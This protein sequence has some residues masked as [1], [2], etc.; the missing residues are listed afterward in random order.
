MGKVLVLSL[1]IILSSS[2][3]AKAQNNEFPYELKKLDYALVGFSAFSKYYAYY[4]EENQVRMTVEELL[5]L[6]RS[7][8]NA[9]DR[10]ATER[11]NN[12]LG[13]I[14]DFTRNILLVAP[15]SIFAFQT[16]NK[17]WKNAFI[18][19]FMY[20]ET[21]LLTW[22]LTDLTKVTVKRK[23]PYLYNTNIP[24]EERIEKIN[25]ENVFDSFYSGHT[26]IA[27]AAATFFS[28]TFTD[29]HGKGM[30]SKVIWASSMSIAATT[31]YLRYASGNHY[32]TDIIVGAIVGGGIGYAIPLIH[33]A[34][35]LNDN[36]SIN[37]G[38]NSL[39]CSYKF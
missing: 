13:E 32:P 21:S 18:Y 28:K 25:D 19:G 14:S 35:V 4:L 33:K 16:V 39:Y 27:F 11:W 29:I 24:I 17:D 10:P 31:G 15:A 12:D 1:L 2:L 9:F 26:A 7:D 5:T 6:D 36:L 20:F 22:G 34:N 30:W 8:I 37:V 23:R 3:L 38:Y